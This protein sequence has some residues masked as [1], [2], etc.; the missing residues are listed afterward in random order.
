MTVIFGLLAAAML[1]YLLFRKV[2]FLSV[3]IVCLLIYNCYCVTGYVYIASHEQVYVNYYEGAIDIRV[4][5]IVIVQMLILFGVTIWYDHK[6]GQEE[7]IHQSFL[8]KNPYDLKKVF[9]IAGIISLLIMVAN[10][11]RIGIDNLSA[12]KEE[13]WPK[14]GTLY[15]T[16]LWLAMAVF[17][18]SVRC[19]EYPLLLLSMPQILLHL[20]FGSRA[21]LAVIAIVFI[22]TLSSRVN[23]FS[24]K[25]NLKIVGVGLAFLIGIMAYKQIFELVKDGD[26][27]GI[28]STLLNPETYLWIFRWGEPRIVLADF[29]YIITENIQLSIPEIASRVCSIFPFADDLFFTNTNRLM[30]AIIYENLNSSYG[31]ASNIW[32]EFYAMGSFPLVLIMYLV[33]VWLLYFGNKLLRNSS[34]MSYFIIPYIAY[35][36]FYIHRMDFIKVL[37]NAKMLLFAMIIWLAMAYAMKRAAPHMA[38]IVQRLFSK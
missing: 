12:P 35:V 22:L 27:Q 33:W 29:N 28:V 14:T 8:K 13:I 10:V 37:G 17:T 23:N 18:F 3:G 7:R 5:I 36:G 15:V 9:I 31:L 38:G 26:I 1:I 32:G 25:L 16:G 24:F 19:K 6:I 20:Y 34:W 21:Y 11:F 30:S 2:D 4:Y